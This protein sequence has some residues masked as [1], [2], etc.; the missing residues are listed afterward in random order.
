M[1]QSF[2]KTWIKNRKQRKIRG[3]WFTQGII[4]FLG[5][6]LTLIALV[7]LLYNVYPCLQSFRFFPFGFFLTVLMQ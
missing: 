4:L 7:P 3:K 6:L 5:A 1:F 2:E